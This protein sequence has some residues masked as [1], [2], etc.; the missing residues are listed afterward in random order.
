[1]KL[2]GNEG[3]ER[4][5]MHL[6]KKKKTFWF[7]FCWACQ[8]VE[9]MQKKSLFSWLQYSSKL[10]FQDQGNSVFHHNSPSQTPA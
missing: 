2:L 3:K 9:I 5:G 7:H 6:K 4:W 10:P 1:M 8:S